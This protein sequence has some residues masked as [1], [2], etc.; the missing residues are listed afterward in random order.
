MDTILYIVRH[1]ET[2][3]NAAGVLQGISPGHLNSNGIK[4]AHIVGDKLRDIHFDA[5][6]CSDIKRC[7]DTADII[8]AGQG[9]N[10]IYLPLLRE[11]DWGS[12]TGKCISLLK[13]KPFPDDVE[14]V[15]SMFN[16]AAEFFKLIKSEFFGKKLLIV[17]H[18]LFSRVLLAFHSGVSISDIARMENAEVRIIKLSG[19]GD[20]EKVTTI[21]ADEISAN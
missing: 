12:L 20:K 17:S 8:T 4:Q 16:R 18:G 13:G 14:S 1:G 19:E 21:D 10:I 15:D 3:E 7:M 2:V 6:L 5:V 11:R 9:Q